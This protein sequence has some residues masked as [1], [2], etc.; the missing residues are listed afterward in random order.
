[1]SWTWPTRILVTFQVAVAAPMALRGDYRELHLTDPP[2]FGYIS[3]ALRP[4]YIGTF[5]R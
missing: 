3:G 5:H 4:Q 1:V 2:H